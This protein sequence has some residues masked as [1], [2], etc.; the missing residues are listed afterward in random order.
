MT[1]PGPIVHLPID[2]IDGREKWANLPRDGRC[3]TGLWF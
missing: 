2:R 3:N 1:V